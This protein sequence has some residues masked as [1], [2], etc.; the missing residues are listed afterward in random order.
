VVSDALNLLN[1]APFP[2]SIVGHTKLPVGAGLG[3][4]AALSVVVLKALASSLQLDLWESDL[5]RFANQLE[6]RFH[7][8]PSGLD[9]TV[10]AYERCICFQR[11]EQ[12]IAPA[13]IVVRS[14]PG[15]PWRFALIDSGI[16]ASTLPM[17]RIAAPYFSGFQAER[18]IERFDRI[19]GQVQIGLEKGDLSA[20]ADGMNEA[21]RLLKKTGIVTDLLDE[22]VTK[23]KKTGVLAAKT[24]GAGGGGFVLTLLDPQRDLPEQLKSLKQMF[25]EQSVFPVDL[26]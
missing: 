14:R 22:I 15:L 10:V 5:A 1:I 8:T 16:R 19:S 6:A 23:S 24:T 11:T 18:R 12:G 26:V 9:T 7:G 25:G 17:I 20:V 13:D 3:S 21:A 2:L 4:S